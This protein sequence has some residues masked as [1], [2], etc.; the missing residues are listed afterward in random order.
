MTVLVNMNR[1]KEAHATAAEA[2][3]K[4][5][6]SP[7]MRYALYQLA[8][9]QSDDAGMAEQVNWSAERAG[10]EAVVLYYQADTAAYLGQLN[11]AR[12]L[13]RQAGASAKRAG[14]KERGAGCEAA[15]AV[16]GAVFGKG[17]GGKR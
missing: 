16:G 4:K 12:E 3:S 1:P 2:A 5:L 10:D 7:D 15:A 17:G 14:R 8:F 6:D 9:L 11:T 13:S